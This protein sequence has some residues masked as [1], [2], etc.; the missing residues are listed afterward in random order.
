MFH[1]RKNAF[2]TI[3]TPNRGHEK[4][5]GG[6]ASENLGTPSIPIVLYVPLYVGSKNNIRGYEKYPQKHNNFHPRKKTP[7]IQ[8]KS[9]TGLETPPF[10]GDA[11]LSRRPSKPFPGG[12]LSIPPA[13]R[14]W[15]WGPSFRRL[16]PRAA[17]WGGRGTVFWPRGVRWRSAAAGVKKCILK[18]A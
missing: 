17:V 16:T 8:L 12:L 5:R 9:Q 13:R 3:E 1:S 14:V 18:Q 2:H 11:L 6:N 15:R 10:H 4:S 7:F